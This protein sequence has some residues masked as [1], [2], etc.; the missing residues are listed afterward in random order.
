MEGILVRS[1]HEMGEFTDKNSIRPLFAAL[2]EQCLNAEAGI[3]TTVLPTIALSETSGQQ[4]RL[5]LAERLH[6]HTILTCHQ[7]RQLNI[8]QGRTD[9]HESIIVA[10]RHSREKPATRF[11]SLDR[12]PKNDDEVAEMHQALLECREGEILGGWGEVSYWPEERIANGDW[13][14]AIWRSHDLAD[15]ASRYANEKNSLEAIG[16]QLASRVAHETGRLLRGSFERAAVD[17]P[18]SFPILKSKGADGQTQLQSKPDEYWIPKKRDEELRKLNGG[19]YLETDK[20]LEKAGYLLITASQNSATARVVATASEEKYVGNAWMPVTGL[21]RNEAKAIAV[22]LN[23]TPGRLQIMRN[24]G[25]AVSFPTYSVAEVGNIRIP[26]VE[27]I[28]ISRI[29]GDCWERTKDMK[30]P[31]FRDGECEVRRLWDEAVADAMGWDAD[32][33]ARLRNLLN[34][35]PHV[36]GLGYNQYGDELDEIEEEEYL[37]G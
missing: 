21:F 32:E 17:T 36:R 16:G 2:A 37:E 20:I 27:D 22:F 18:G 4:E 30:V 12:M 14:P 31:Q 9:A 7:P 13:T 6:I 24:A 33:L 11:I 15:A 23:S 19:T 35:E 3:M 26:D 25:K 5:T 1:D 29:L 28:H 34:Q 10:N 8:S